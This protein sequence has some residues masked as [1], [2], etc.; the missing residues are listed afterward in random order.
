MTPRK[1]VP[2]IV[3]TARLPC[4]GAPQ[5]ARKRG[6]QCENRPADSLQLRGE[7]IRIVGYC[8]PN[9]W[10]A[11]AGI[12]FRAGSAVAKRIGMG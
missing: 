11:C 4:P 2:R 6:R 7:T 1:K 8:G 3:P 12:A 10:R 5:T 9:T